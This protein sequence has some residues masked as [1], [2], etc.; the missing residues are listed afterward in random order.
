MKL[1]VKNDHELFNNISKLFNQFQEE[2]K[3]YEID[4]TKKELSDIYNRHTGKTPI[5]RDRPKWHCST[6]RNAIR[7]VSKAVAIN[8][9]YK[10]LP[11]MEFV[12][13]KI[14]LTNNYP[15]LYDMF[16]EF[17]KL[18]STSKVKGIFYSKDPLLGIE[19]NI[20]N[21]T[22]LIFYHFHFNVNTEYQHEVQ[23]NNRFTA[24]KSTISKYQSHIN[25]LKDV[26]FYI[27]EN[28][29]YR[30]SEKTNLLETTVNLLSQYRPDVDINNF[31]LKNIFSNATFFNNDVISTLVDDLISGVDN[32]TAVNS[33]NKKVAPENY[34]QSRTNIISQ[35]QVN[36][37]QT[38]LEKLGYANFIKGFNFAEPQDINILD[39][40]WTNRK[41]DTNG[42]LTDLLTNNIKPPKVVDNNITE[43]PL[44]KFLQKLETTKSI[45]VNVNE[46]AKLVLIKDTFVEPV[47]KWNNHISYCY[48]TGLADVDIVSKKIK[49]K[50]GIIDAEIR[51]SLYWE[52]LDD[53]DLHLK[54]SSGNHIYYGRKQLPTSSFE[55]DID[56]NAHKL[57]RGAV[58]NIFC[59]KI[60]FNKGNTF[61]VYVHNFNQRQLPQK[62]ILNI[63]VKN[64][65]TKQYQFLNP[66]NNEHTVFLRF[67]VDND[68]KMEIIW[69]NKE[70]EKTIQPEVKFVKVD[71]VLL[72]PNYWS[73]GEGNKHIF[74]LRKGE[75]IELTNLRPYNIEQL[76]PELIK[77]RKVLQLLTNRIEIKGKPQ[78]VGYGISFAKRRKI[79]TK[80]NKRLYKLIINSNDSTDK[81][82]SDQLSQQVLVG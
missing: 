23:I 80:V 10:R 2:Y 8:D 43:I 19:R 67:K 3:L 82:I 74:F 58:E 29:I 53:L 41:V 12:L 26:L 39:I 35:T 68:G 40:L 52:N 56:M 15:F 22:E 28:Y 14:D 70:Y 25:I 6:C 55:L 64:R 20:E 7:K 42:K 36:Q 44:I 62:C 18:A 21:L 13:S 60:M 49:E 33:Y 69:S 37:C 9:N 72:S 24:L 71:T 48:D 76:R 63:Y 34:Q 45:E 75:G 1:I 31:T 51:F 32:E 17:S 38:E 77:H 57:I 4:A 46:L 78:L 59:K 54:D 47:Y 65:L 50:G 73:K 27:H 66:P 5:F 16:V 11:F 30:G 61:K 79:L 81:V